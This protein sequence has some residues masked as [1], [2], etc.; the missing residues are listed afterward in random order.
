MMYKNLY[1]ALFCFFSFFSL[2]AETINKI[3]INGNKRISTETIKIY[4]EIELNKN[5]SE[6][7]TN[8]ILKN[9][10]KTDFFE[11]VEIE[12]IGD[13]MSITVIEYPF[14]NQLLIV[15]E[16]SNNYKEQ[17]KKIIKLK[18]KRSFIKSYLSE[19]LETIKSLY[20][21]R[22][23]NSAEIEIKTKKI[24]DNSFDLLVEINRGDKTKISSINFIGNNKIKSRRLKDVIASE[25]NKFWKI[26]TTN[27]N[28]NKRLLE[29]D[30]RLLRNFYK[31]NGFY[32]VRI[33]SKVAKLND[34]NQAELSYTITEGERYTINKISTNI[35]QVFDKKIFFP[36]NKIYKNYI[37]EYY[38]PFKIKKLLEDLDDLIDQNSLQFVEHNVEEQIS[39]TEINVIINIYEGEKTTVERINITG[40]SVTNEDVIRGE[41]IVDEGDPFSKLNLDKS[42]AEIKSRRI[43]RDVK[44]EI[45]EG[46]ENN[47]KIININVEEQPTGEINA[48]AGVGTDGGLF[49][50][51][52]KENNWLGTGKSVSFDVEVDSESFT[53]SFNYVDPNYDFLG[54]SLSYTLVSETND[55][56]EQ[57]YENSLTSIGIGTS[58]EQYRDV[59]LS[60]GLNASHDDL[61]TVSTAS[62]SL[63]KQEGTYSEIAGNYG[64]TFDTR[65]RSFMPTKG[66][67]IKFGQALP[68]YADSP[69]ITNFVSASKYKAL[70]ENVIGV[71]KLYLATIDG[72]GSENVRLSKR[73]GLST[74]RLRGFEK[75]KIGPV[76]NKDHVGGNYAAAVNFEANLPNFLPDD[77]NA[78]I[79]V[80][81]DFGNVWGVDYNSEIDESNKIRSSTGIIANWMSPIGP[82][83]FVLSQNLS[84][85]NTDKTQSFNF[86]LGTTF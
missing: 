57:G 71:G 5:Y 40:N 25:E 60:L 58:F 28:F 2:N 39:G 3:N 21:S 49:S 51:G 24:T 72:L 63:Q 46:S 45:E 15:G 67:I 82:M 66:S 9:L 37:G 64:F 35:D 54:N 19:D 23:Y 1:V 55:K 43:F 75:S 48:G 74:K 7:D 77:T 16:K 53:G 65:D 68:L 44:Y 22:G 10:Y 20:S 29:L 38:S 13:Q 78:D 11:E 6:S 50:I 79:S 32:D 31:S 12:I 17:I 73:K 4:G 27:T 76:D 34:N 26:L 59:F 42:V 84:K 8:Q 70:N 18:E 56:P 14:I 30:T 41:L 81:L 86:N 61:R 69:S 52:V 62:S 47:L 83:N 85:A 80:F 33:N 36:L